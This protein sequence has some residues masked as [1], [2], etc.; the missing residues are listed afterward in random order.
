MYYGGTGC[1]AV[2]YIFLSPRLMMDLFTAYVSL[3]AILLL[4]LEKMKE[5]KGLKISTDATRRMQLCILSPPS[6]NTTS[7]EYW[8]IH[9][10]NRPDTV[11]QNLIYQE[12]QDEAYVFILVII[13]VTHF[14]MWRK[15]SVLV[16][17]HCSIRLHHHCN[18]LLSSLL[19]SILISIKTTGR[20]AH[21]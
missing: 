18:L 1:F 5:R 13:L 11:A 14:R 15:M 9:M 4:L 21:K 16:V 17:M 10:T 19:F 7:A 12:S 20:L 8:W 6:S 3:S 2:S